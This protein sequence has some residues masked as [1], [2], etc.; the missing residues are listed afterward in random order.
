MTNY[1][2]G[3]FLLG[4][5][6]F[7]AMILAS[8]HDLA[9]SPK[10]II[11]LVPSQTELLYALGLEAET[12]AI[13]KFCVHPKTWFQSKTR[14]G[15]T[16]TINIDKV[17]SLRPDLII[18]NKEENV[19]EQVEMLAEHFPVWVSDVN[20]LDEAYQMVQ[21]IGILTKTENIAAELVSAIKHMFNIFIQN[22]NIKKRISTAYLIWKDPYMTVGRD[23]FISDLMGVAGLENVFH[24]QLRYPEIT[25]SKLKQLNCKL[26]L[27]SSEPYPFKEKHIE[28]LQRE[29]PGVK[30]ILVDGELFSWYGSRLLHSPAYFEK[31][32]SEI[33]N[34]L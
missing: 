18:A 17:I 26:V 32:R 29:L 20:T 4:I 33:E 34:D 13:T 6:Y 14:I 10:K 5:S 24:E 22:N 25:L 9:Y 8:P 28:E 21:D 12:I 3:F 31:L 2:G 1:C 15:G 11:S 30:I 27:L 7:Y 23:S 19:K 16:K